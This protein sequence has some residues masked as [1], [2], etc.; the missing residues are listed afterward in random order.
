MS[1][2]EQGE[3]KSMGI[4]WHVMSEEDHW[5]F[6]KNVSGDHTILWRLAVV[7]TIQL[8]RLTEEDASDGLGCHEDVDGFSQSLQMRD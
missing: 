1:Y 2:N 5:M 4:Y 3:C 7:G 8:V 6:Y